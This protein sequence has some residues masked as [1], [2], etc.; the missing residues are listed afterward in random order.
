MYNHIL[1][2]G[3]K[4]FCRYYLQAFRTVERLKC[5]VKDC[6]K[7]N[8]KQRIKMT[9]KYFRFINYERKIKSPFAIY[10]DFESILVPE[11]NRK[12]NPGEFYL[13]KYKKHIPCSYYY[14]L[15]CVDKKFSKPFKPYLGKDEVYNYINSMIKGSK[16]WSGMMKKRF[17]KELVVTE[18]DNEDFE[19][20][21]KYWICNNS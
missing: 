21:T 8:G 15:L 6:F 13:N 19:S 14:N 16:Y 20:S 18:E 2:R 11:D 4:N 7:I 3:R 5:Y 1:N 9:R 17:N 12:E 10:A